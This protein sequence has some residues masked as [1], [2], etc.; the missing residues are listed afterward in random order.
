MPSNENYDNDC[1]EADRMLVQITLKVFQAR[2]GG[3]SPKRRRMA[4]LA[5]FPHV[6]FSCRFLLKAKFTPTHMRLEWKVW[7]LYIESSQQRYPGAK[8]GTKRDVLSIEDPC[9]TKHCLK[10]CLLSMHNKESNPLECSHS[11]S[12]LHP[13]STNVIFGDFLLNFFRHAA[14]P[15]DHRRRESS[16]TQKNL[17]SQ[18]PRSNGGVLTI[19]KTVLSTKKGWSKKIWNHW[20]EWSIHLKSCS[21]YEFYWRTHGFLFVGSKEPSKILETN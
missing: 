6:F 21:S 13:T 17:N 5:R 20:K 10:Q 12:A 4:F 18:G 14:A 7:T 15:C 16:F 19:S 1:I 3:F 8:Q 9:T 11:P 2:H